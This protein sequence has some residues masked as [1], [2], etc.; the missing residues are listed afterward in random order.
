MSTVV[1]TDKQMPYP[2]GR[3]TG[4][5]NAEGEITSTLMFRV[6]SEEQAETYLLGELHP[7]LGIPEASRT[8]E[9]DEVCE[10]GFELSIVY[11][12]KRDDGGS[13]A[14]Y[15]LDYSFSEEPIQAHPKWLEI[16]KKYRGSVNPEGEV[17]FPEYIKMPTGNFFNK[18]EKKRVK[19]PMFGVKTYLVLKAIHRETFTSRSR[20]SLSRYGRIKKS[21]P[22]GFDTPEDHDW[23][24]LPPKAKRKGV[25]EYQVVIESILSPLG[26]FTEGVYE[27][28]EGR[29]NAR[30]EDTDP[31]NLGQDPFVPVTGWNL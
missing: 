25:D 29:G 6:A 21:V 10:L 15:E 12:G 23:L 18:G 22:G 30:E 17:E 20:P 4:S 7:T 8:W 5:R 28:M 26:G 31:L 13:V 24:E 11:R 2:V 3:I 9:E 19:N 1:H 27:L 14:E 16:K